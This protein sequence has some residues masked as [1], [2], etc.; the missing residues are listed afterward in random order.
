MTTARISAKGQVTI[1][2]DVRRQLNL[3]QGDN[4]SFARIG[5]NFF[6]AKNDNMLFEDSD[7]FGF[8]PEYPDITS[9]SDIS[10]LCKSLRCETAGN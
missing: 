1:P 4:I 8:N 9:I 10:D 2:V 6:I 5:K 3:K 7:F